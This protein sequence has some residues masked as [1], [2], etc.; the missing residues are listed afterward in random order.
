MEETRPDARRGQG[1]NASVAALAAITA[2]TGLAMFATPASAASGKAS[3]PDPAA[4]LMNRAI[5]AKAGLHIS[6][7]L[8]QGGTDGLS[9]YL[10]DGAQPPVQRSGTAAHLPPAVIA[11]FDVSGLG[12]T[13]AKKG[14]A[15]RSSVVVHGI[16]GSGTEYLAGGT[17][18]QPLA[19]G[20]AKAGTG[21]RTVSID[22]TPAGR[23]SVSV[24]LHDG[25][26]PRPMLSN[27][28]LGQIKGLPKL[29]A[30][31]KLGVVAKKH[32]TVPKVTVASLL[33]ELRVAVTPVA[34]LRKGA[35][36]GLAIRVADDP[37]AGPTTGRVTSTFVVPT[38]MTVTSATGAGGNC[39]VAGQRVTCTR[40]GT[41]ADALA[42]GESYPPIRVNVAVHPDAPNDVAVQPVV[43]TVGNRADGGRQA[44]TMI[45][46]AGV[47]AKPGPAPVFGAPHPTQPAKNPSKPTAPAPSPSGPATAPGATTNPGGPATTP[48][49]STAPAIPAPST[50]ALVPGGPAQPNP[51]LGTPGKSAPGTAPG[52]TA[53]GKPGTPPAA[54][55]PAKSAPA[56]ADPAHGDSAVGNP[57]PGAPAPAKSPS[58]PTPAPVAPAKGPNLSTG[59]SHEGAPTAGKPTVYTVTVANDKSAGP[60]SEPVRT[61]FTAPAGQ[62]P[63]AAT[64]TGWACTI[65]G[66]T[67]TCTRSGSGADA[68]KPGASYPPIKVTVPM[69]ATDGGQRTT[70]TATTS[71]KNDADPANNAARPDP[72][73]IVAARIPRTG[74]KVG[75]ETS[76]DPYK[77]GGQVTYTAT[78]TN[79]GP[80]AADSARLV[81]QVPDLWSR[82]AWTCRPTGGAKCPSKT[83]FGSIDTKID[84]PKGGR[85]VFTAAR[86]LPASFA[87]TLMGQATVIPPTGA[88][89]AICTTSGCTTINTNSHGAAPS[90]LTVFPEVF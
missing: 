76:P 27:V 59:V 56:A 13:T 58:K 67:A 90:P 78:V 37:A 28:A 40:P 83:G 61:V 44:P 70:P 39:G 31:V 77:K 55:A 87:G 4:L 10:V 89:D 75:F 17:A 36:G 51:V 21:R 3:V 85:L 84:V 86:R 47:P 79:A 26:G 65:A 88:K 23:M 20:S 69:P 74:L 64:G 50:S 68:L 9:F 60:T 24:D 52:M 34:P 14:S 81:A 1:R 8:Y 72:A 22:V 19:T 66:Q 49:A 43:T 25:K 71:T 12:G 63:S 32:H 15:G 48:G 82:V 53:P 57:V 62:R 35:A 33:P 30:T 38:G 29:P 6:F 45:P 46:I 41:N 54:P 18:A 42:S 7:D 73:T 5:S 16:D 80:D 11:G 2:V